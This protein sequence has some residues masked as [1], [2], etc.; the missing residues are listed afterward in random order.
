[1]MRTDSQCHLPARFISTVIIG[2]LVILSLPLTGQNTA[3]ARRSVAELERALR[4][5]SELQARALNTIDIEIAYRMPRQVAGHRIEIFDSAGTSVFS[6][7]MPKGK[8]GQ[9]TMRFQGK[10]GWMYYVAIVRRGR[11]V[12]AVKLELPCIGIRILSR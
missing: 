9:D 12:R 3:P 1:M 6:Q 8:S 2:F 4:E 5:G 10:I 7:A 11:I